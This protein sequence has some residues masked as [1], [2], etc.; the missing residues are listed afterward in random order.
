MLA[1]AWIWEVHQG[2]GYVGAFTCSLSADAPYLLAGEACNLND[3][4]LNGY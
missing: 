2:V 1:L 3:N 4:I